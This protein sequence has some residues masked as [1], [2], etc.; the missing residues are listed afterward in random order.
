MLLHVVCCAVTSGENLD[1]SFNVFFVWY[2]V[3][4]IDGILCVYVNVV[5]HGV[6]LVSVSCI[7]QVWCIRSGCTDGCVVPV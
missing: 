5:C 7:F 1:I 4:N 3:V 2:C 6:G